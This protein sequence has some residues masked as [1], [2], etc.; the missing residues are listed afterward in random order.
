MPKNNIPSTSPTHT[1]VPVIG[2]AKRWVIRSIGQI[3]PSSCVTS[4]TPAYPARSAQ[5]RR[6]VRRAGIEWEKDQAERYSGI[7]IA[8][9]VDEVHRSPQ[10]IARYCGLTTNAAAVASPTHASIPAASDLAP[11]LSQGPVQLRRGRAA[12]PT[13]AE[14]EAQP[15]VITSPCRPSKRKCATVGVGVPIAGPGRANGP[16]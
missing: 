15:G 3:V 13:P 9:V 11:E 6:A 5:A 1:D 12:A 8:D 10:S 2:S 14:G 7:G 16:I 4:S